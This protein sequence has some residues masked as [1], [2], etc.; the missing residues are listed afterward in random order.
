MATRQEVFDYIINNYAASPVYTFKKFPHYATF[1]TPS[2]K[3]FAP[4]MNV[5]QNKLGL[6]GTAEIDVKVD[7]ELASILRQNP[8]YLPAYHMN[9]EHWLTVVLNDQT[10]RQT[11]NQLIDDSYNLVN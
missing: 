9:K 5:P 7:P 10:D 11:L 4:V 8:G 2:G 1:K 6:T 3:W